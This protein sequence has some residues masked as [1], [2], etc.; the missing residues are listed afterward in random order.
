MS[1]LCQ[2][3]L[4]DWLAFMSCLII[5]I[6]EICTSSTPYLNFPKKNHSGNIHMQ[7]SMCCI[8]EKWIVDS[9]EK[10]KENHALILTFDV[11]R[12]LCL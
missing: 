3:V 10:Y 5:Y 1:C 7:C 4:C 2:C 6:N 9:D 8:V 11:H 12:I